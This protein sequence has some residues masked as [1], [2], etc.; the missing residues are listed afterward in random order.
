MAKSTVFR[1]LMKDKNVT[2]AKLRAQN[3]RMRKALERI[4]KFEH[5]EVGNCNCPVGIAHEMIKETE[6]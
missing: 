3:E 5:Q 4:S 6:K 1:E 2:V